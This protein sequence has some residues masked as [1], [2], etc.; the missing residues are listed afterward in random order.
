MFGKN[1][2]T[3]DEF[4]KRFTNYLQV[5]AEIKK[6]ISSGAVKE[7]TLGHNKFSDQSDED[8]GG[9]SSK[10]DIKMAKISSST[11]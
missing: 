10:F 3:Q 11:E 4:N 7:T 6:A 8:M 9:H 2:S 5:D 1:Y